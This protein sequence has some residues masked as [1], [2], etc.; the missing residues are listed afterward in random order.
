[1]YN[2]IVVGAGVSGIA[3][4]YYLKR[5]GIPFRILE[6]SVE[7]GGTWRD[8]KWHGARV[9]TEVVEYCFSFK[10]EIPSEKFWDRRRVNRYLRAVAEEFGIEEYIE[11]NK[12][13]KQASFCSATNKWTVVTADGSIFEANFLYNCNGFGGMNAFIP[14]L[15]GIEKFGG[16]VFHSTELEDSRTFTHQRVVIVGSGATAISSAPAL[17]DVSKELTI[18]QRSPSY[19]YE[20]DTEPDMFWNLFRILHS[21]GWKGAGRLLQFLRMV[22]DDILFTLIRKLPRL[23]RYYFYNHWARDVGATFADAHMIPIYKALQQRICVSVGLKERINSGAI[24]FETGL[25]SRF[26]ENGIVL[27][28]GKYIPCDVCV[29]ATG[30]NLNILS[31]PLDCDGK[32]YNL[33]RVNFYKTFMLGGVP[34]YFQPFGCFD[35]S[36]TG[37]IERICAFTTKIIEKMYKSGSTKLLVPRKDVPFDHVFTPNYIKRN[38]ATPRPYGLWNNPTMDFLFSFHIATC[39]EL[40]FFYSSPGGDIGK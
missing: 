28:S 37:R 12:Y 13:V 26:D 31:F 4:G 16:E 19:V 33:D 6:A 24:K 15:D 27:K 5:A 23:A 10:V 21:L 35:C 14:H 39:K 32:V 17:S 9:D 1:M 3:A 25:V 2:A 20:A 29:L 11:Y 38:K 8:Q 18:L 7:T 36:W 34:N 22:N 40:K 30:F